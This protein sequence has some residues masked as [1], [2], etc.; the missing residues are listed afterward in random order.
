MFEE[1]CWIFEHDHVW[2]HK[3]RSPVKN[4]NTSSTK[5]KIQIFVK[6]LD[7]G[8]FPKGFFPSGN[9]PR[10]IFQVATSQMCNFTNRQ[11]HKCKFFQMTIYQVASSPWK[12]SGNFPNVHFPKQQFPLI[13]YYIFFKVS[14]SHSARPASPS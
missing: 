6:F 9:F 7:V 1:N 11:L 13:I 3:I 14:N 2:F 4:Q 10:V 8:Y 12:K 5:K